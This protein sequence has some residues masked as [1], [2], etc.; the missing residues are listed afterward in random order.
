M[1]ASE[2]WKVDEANLLVER[3]LALCEAAV[4]AGGEYCIENPID[5]G[6][7]ALTT[8]FSEPDHCPMWQ[9]PEVQQMQRRT[10]GVPVHFPQCAFEGALF[11]KWTTLLVSSGLAAG[12]AWLG[13]LRCTHD[14]H[15]L[16]AAGYDEAGEP[17]GPRAAAYPSGLTY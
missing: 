4:Q 14:S 2:R 10:G 9:L 15:E 17:T 16:Q 7:P 8:V 12:A 1:S 13:R 6:D 11:Q 5:R 3:T